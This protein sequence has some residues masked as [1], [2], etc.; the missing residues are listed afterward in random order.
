MV[1]FCTSL[2]PSLGLAVIVVLFCGLALGQQFQIPRKQPR[3]FAQHGT[4]LLLA[5]LVMAFISMA[6]FLVYIFGPRAGC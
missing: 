6:I 5:M 3:G 4:R 1:K 2:Y